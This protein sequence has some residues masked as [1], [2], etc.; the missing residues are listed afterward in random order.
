MPSMQSQPGRDT[1]FRLLVIGDYSGRAGRASDAPTEL[2]RPVHV[3]RDNVED[4]MAS[5]TPTLRLE[6]AGAEPFEISFREMD[7]FHPDRLVLR[8]ESLRRLR[9]LRSRLRQKDLFP[10]A[11]RELADLI[12]APPESSAEEAA[13][14][15]ARD[16]GGEVVTAADLF[17]DSLDATTERAESASTDW[18]QVVRDL[19]GSELRGMRITK[20]TTEQAECV[21]R[22]DQVIASALQQILHAPPFQALEAAWRSLYK[23]VRQ[24]RTGRLLK[25]HLLD[26]TSAALFADL[27]SAKDLRDTRLHRLLVEPTVEV[28]GGEP[29]AAFICDLRFD[30][31]PRDVLFLSR[32]ARLA[33]NA[34]AALIGGAA[35][36]VFGCKSLGATPHPSDW[37]EPADP[38]GGAAWSQIREMPAIAHVSLIA[39]RVL[40]RVPYGR[41][42]D[43]TEDIPFEEMPDGPVHGAYLWGNASFVAAEALAAQFEARGWDLRPEVTFD[44]DDLP[45]HLYDDDGE[46]TLAPCAE[47]LLT[48]RGVDRIATAG[49]VPL[50]SIRNQAAVRLGALHC[51]AGAEYALAGPWQ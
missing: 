6:G 23:L 1:P 40:L 5:L 47:A 3:D 18:D 26:A 11:A 31:V 41:D 8:V 12:G 34:G 46:S 35:P 44:K 49:V 27:G 33:A 15:A 22:L 29:W 28:E 10:D 20:E 50:L 48:E 9:D 30:A 19:V 45:A 2:S 21:E 17:G 32:L 38:V 42:H 37:N 7:D 39:P 51:L 24:L 25:V 16:P 4:V 13:P 43:P 36:G 14:D